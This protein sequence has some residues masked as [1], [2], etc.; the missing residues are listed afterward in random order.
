MPAAIIAL[1]LA[2]SAG[3]GARASFR[4]RAVAYSYLNSSG[5]ASRPLTFGIYPGGAAG[6]VGPSGQLKPEDPAKRLQALEE[7]R[8]ASVPFV[9]HLYAS[10][11]GPRGWSAAQQLGQQIAQY[12]GAGFEIEL[13]LT[14]RP[15]GGGSA[16]DVSGFV[17]FVHA[18]LSSFGANRRF[19]ALQVTNEA[20]ISGAPNAADGYY[21]GAQD[22]LIAGV[23]AAKQQIL[24][25]GYGQ[26]K[27]GFNW[28]YSN[29]DSGF[30]R[31]L[32]AQGG[33]SFVRSLDW[34]GL[35]VYP[36][37]W[38]PESPGSLPAATASTMQTALAS[39][40]TNY[41]P[42]AGIPARVAL[43]VSENGYPT[44]PG[45]TEQMQVQ[46]MRAAINTV[47]ADRALYNVTD[48]RW[49]DLRDAASA[50]S[51][52][53]DRYGLMTDAYTPKLAFAV[54]R[55]LVAELGV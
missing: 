26:V 47:E 28:A 49:F 42:L 17:D 41:L 10:Y 39:L 51:S 24:A 15:D 34:V 2:F 16:A 50:S 38:G 44:G 12:T 3:A 22:A 36:G 23:I 37:T 33:A 5:L 48:Y 8:P 7:L 32:G 29:G 25:S 1:A 27:V 4:A 46:V 54:Y 31:Q 20:N 43:H 30:W 9:L 52:F 40:R 55:S 45:R 6:T 18:A 19:V 35:D 14:Y 11:T 21:A 53:E 13:V